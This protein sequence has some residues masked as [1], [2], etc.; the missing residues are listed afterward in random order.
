MANARGNVTS[1]GRY[2][3]DARRSRTVARLPSTVGRTSRAEGAMTTDNTTTIGPA[4]AAGDDAPPDSHHHPPPRALQHVLGVLGRYWATTTVVVA[5][6][7]IGLATGAFWNQVVEGT[8]LY[9]H[10]AYGLPSLQEGRWWTFLSGMFFAPELIL[11]LPIVALLVI[12]ASVYERRVGHVRVLIVTIGGQFLG[13]LLTAL[14][15][16][17]FVD[18]GWTWATT[19]GAERDLGIS[20]GGFALLG[21][22]SAV[23]QPVW[24]TR[25]RIGFGAYLIAMVLNS[26][27]LWDVEHFLA[28]VLGV[29]AGPFL[30]PRAPIRP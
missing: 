21:A 27:L 18:S 6:I 13:A 17:I 3:R 15:L 2:R 29:V 26:G 1:T 19:L 28:F 5:L 8:S 25:I 12:V 7:V 23:M 22:L 14:F 20:A 30:V 9:G 24:R 16:W 10:V 11:Y 4:D